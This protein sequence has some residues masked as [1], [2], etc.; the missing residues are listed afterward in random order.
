MN[1]AESEL[2]QAIMS[3]AQQLTTLQL[4]NAQSAQDS[5]KALSHLPLVTLQ[6]T[7]T[8]RINGL[9]HVATIRLEQKEY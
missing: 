5:N 9:R 6:G 2:A 8:K 4:A 3:V 1:T 7:V